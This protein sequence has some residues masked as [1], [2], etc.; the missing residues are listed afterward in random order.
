MMRHVYP[1]Y[2]LFP[3]QFTHFMISEVYVF[4]AEDII[5]FLEQNLWYLLHDFTVGYARS[6]INSQVLETLSTSDTKSRNT[7]PALNFDSYIRELLQLHDTIKIIEI[8][9]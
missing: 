1:F 3:T 5:L 8:M 6:T 2:V 7:F 4:F 9:H